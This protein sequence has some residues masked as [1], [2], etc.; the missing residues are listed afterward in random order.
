MP[1]SKSTPWFDLKAMHLP[2]AEIA[3]AYSVSIKPVDGLP[4][5]FTLAY[6]A[7][8]TDDAPTVL[9]MS[10]PSVPPDKTTSRASVTKVTLVPLALIAGK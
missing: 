2:S 1:A 8:V 7:E 6:A 10:P 9:T 3:G 5:G 4:F